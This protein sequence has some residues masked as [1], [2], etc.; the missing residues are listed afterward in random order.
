M[1]VEK[2]FEKPPVRRSGLR[3]KH[4]EALPAPGACIAELLCYCCWGENSR[5]NIQTASNGKVSSSTILA[6]QGSQRIEDNI[7]G[8]FGTK[9]LGTSS[10]YRVVRT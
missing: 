7:S 8:V 10:R 2:L 9:F 6:T 1:Q 5:I 3:K 4:Q